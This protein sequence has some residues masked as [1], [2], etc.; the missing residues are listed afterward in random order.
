[1]SKRMNRRSF[2]QIFVVSASASGTGLLSACVD[3]E[4]SSD[5]ADQL[6]VYPQGLASGDPH[7][8]SVILWTR[9]E[10]EGEA[11]VTVTCEVASDEAFATIVFQ[12]EFTVD[13]SSDHALR[14]KVQKLAPYTFYYYRFVARGVISET[15]RTKTAPKEDEDVPVRFAFASC[16]DYNGRYYHAYRALV[17]QEPDL[18]FVLHLG[19][20]IYETEGDPRFQEPTQERRIVLP[21][22]LPIGTAE[23]PYSAAKSLADY[24]YLYRTYR[25]DPDLRRAHARYPFIAI[26]DDHEFADDSW[27]DHSTHFNE[28]QGGEKDPV[29]RQSASQAWYEYQPADVTHIASGSF[30]DDITIYRSLRYGAHV[31]LILTDQRYYRDDHL[32]PEGPL[33][34]DV[35]K[36]F[37]NSSL[38]SR[39]LVIKLGTDTVT[40]EPIGFDIREANI[41][42][43]MLG[44]TQKQWLIDTMTNSTATWKFWGNETQLA[45]MVLDLRNNMQLP[46]SFQALFYF[47]VDQWDGYRSERAEILQAIAEVPNVVALT[48]D[49]H[50]FYAC[51]IHPDFDAPATP[52]CVEYTVAG[53]SSLA[54]QDIVQRVIDSEPALSSLGLGDLVPQFDTLLQQA[55]PH[56]LYAKSKANGIAVAA[57]TAEDIQVTFMEVADVTNPDFD[58][59]VTRVSFR[60]AVDTTDIEMM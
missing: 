43:T 35:G 8:D 21:D 29:R 46:A 27:Q 25:S 59:N 56:Y 28:A 37:E 34:T 60:T 32:I 3:D 54:V 15:G 40:G 51:Q 39:Q 9:V 58:G 14:V 47:T 30:P 7:E 33:D 13:G 42:P 22:G 38:G 19:D 18:D 2:L 41:K 20:Y 11:S 6:R 10:P 53:V 36:V 50:A 23:A 55:S 5:P 57:V 48:G 16:Q 49:I 1:M 45:Q 44:A 24:R 4:L 26:W 52:T 31:E 12:G 17:E